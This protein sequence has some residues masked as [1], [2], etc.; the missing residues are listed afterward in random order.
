[1]V[2]VSV[3]YDE[4]PV[5]RPSK[6]KIDANHKGFKGSVR[7][8]RTIMQNKPKINLFFKPSIA[9]LLIKKSWNDHHICGGVWLHMA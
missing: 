7:P 5:G 9:L 4:L 3:L 2:L 8:N 6:M 1:M